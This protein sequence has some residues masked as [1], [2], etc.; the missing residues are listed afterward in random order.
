[1]LN[2]VVVADLPES[3][4]ILKV[5]VIAACHSQESLRV[6]NRLLMCQHF[7]LNRLAHTPY[8]FNIIYKTKLYHFPL[9]QIVKL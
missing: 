4:A 3:P 9:A 2:L 6:G 8:H 7:C 5:L 1:M